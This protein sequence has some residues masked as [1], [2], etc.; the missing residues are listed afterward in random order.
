MPCTV[1]NQLYLRM[2]PVVTVL[3][4]VSQGFGRTVA[5]GRSGTMM[6]VFAVRFQPI[7][8]SLISALLKKLNVKFVV[9]HVA[10]TI[11]VQIQP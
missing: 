6:V 5:C 10:S 9:K 1:V 8:K 11:V 7:M 4:W 3:I 2:A